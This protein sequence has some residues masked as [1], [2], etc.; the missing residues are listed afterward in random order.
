MMGVLLV[1]PL[2]EAQRRG[3]DEGFG[4][5]G[6]FIVGVDRLFSLFE[7][8][9]NSYDEF[10]PFPG[11]TKTV[12]STTQT[13]LG[14]FWGGT[15]NGVESIYTVPRVGLDY[16]IINNVTIG[17]ELIAFFTLGGSKNTEDDTNNSSTTA[18]NGLP[19]ATV[20][21]LAIRGGYILALSDM[22]SLWFRGG[23]SDYAVTSKTTVTMGN[24]TTENT[25][26]Y[27]QFALDLDPQ[28][29]F[30]PFRHVGFTAGLTADIPIGG[31][32]WSDTNITTPGMSA[33]AHASAPSSYAFVGLTIGTLVWF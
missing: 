7:Y 4:E 23:F 29:V 24:I 16:T 30:T 15:F 2:A 27:K 17:G 11:D 20:L 21:G 13:S 31:E 26:G 25:L 18:H 10:V 1:A 28:F 5:R 22:F 6:Q 32:H 19:G 9:Q 8:Q 3:G 14:F 33:S 12:Q